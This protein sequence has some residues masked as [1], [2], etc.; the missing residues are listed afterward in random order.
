MMIFRLR[1]SLIALIVACNACGL[2]GWSQLAYGQSASEQNSPRLKPYSFV[3]YW[4]HDAVGYHPA[5]IFRVENVSGSDLTGERIKFQGKFTDLNN[6]QGTIDRKE[7]RTEFRNNQE[8]QVS[9]IGPTAFELPID[10]F[11]WPQIEAKV[12]CR[13]GEVGDEGT[14]TLLIENLERQTMT[15]EEASQRLAQFVP[16]M[17]SGPKPKPQPQPHHNERPMVATALPL[18]AGTHKFA[19]NDKTAFTKFIALPRLAGLGEDFYDFDQVYGKT[20]D[21]DATNEKW[22]WVHYN[23]NALDLFVGAKGRT[24][25]ADTIVAV[26]PASEVQQEGQLVLLA[27]AMA[28]K[29]KNQPVES[30]VH[31]VKYLPSGRLQLT[32][33]SAPG[34]KVIY[35]NPRGMGDDNNYV[36]VMSRLGGDLRG[37]LAESVKRTRMLKFLQPIVEGAEPD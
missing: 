34:Y 19:P 18:S 28:G 8:I 3:T 35:V 6:G 9:L 26:V 22:T 24:N 1:K 10:K 17:R 14:Q 21:F 20:D 25:R 37:G 7:V 32:N 11:R 16:A 12:M 30:P 15:D 27:K 23:N 29:F 31:S 5:I 4:S 13:V 2:P 33:F 36:L